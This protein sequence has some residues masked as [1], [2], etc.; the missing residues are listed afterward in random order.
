MAEWVV[1]ALLLA[2]KVIEEKNGK[3]GLIGIFQQFNFPQFPAAVPIPWF[4][5]ASISN[6]EEGTRSFTFNLV[7]DETQAVIFSASREMN[8]ETPCSSIDLVVVVASVRFDAP[9]TYTLTFNID[10]APAG[11][12]V[13][14]VKKVQ[15]QTA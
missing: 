14:D 9:G 13:V 1:N 6:V 15:P 10:G 7:R 5:Y 3:K 8:V 2:D 12:R 11:S 4:V